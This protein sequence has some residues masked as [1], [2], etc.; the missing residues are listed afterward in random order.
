MDG[1]NAQANEV[2][3]FSYRLEQLELSGD[4]RVI[5]EPSEISHRLVPSPV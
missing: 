3:L 5:W 4:E 1:G 2:M